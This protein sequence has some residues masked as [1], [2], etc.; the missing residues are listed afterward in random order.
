M[1]ENWQDHVAAAVFAATTTSWFSLVDK[2]V[3]V[4]YLDEFFHIPQAQ[5][6]CAG[7]YTWDPKITTPPGLYL[8]AKLLSPVLGCSLRSLRVQNVFALSFI[9]FKALQIRRLIQP[10]GHTQ[11]KAGLSIPDPSKDTPDEQVWT[12]NQTPFSTA[13][14]AFNIA[15]FPPLFFFGGL[16]YTDVMST[17]AVLISYDVFIKRAAKP[18]WSITDDLLTVVI[19][20]IAF[21]FR[22]TNIFWVAVFPAGLTVIRVLK[23]NGHT[24]ASVT[25]QGYLGLL[26]SSWSKGLIYDRSL[27]EGGLS[28][29][30]ATMLLLTIA[31]S[32][33]RSP[34]KLLRS[35]IPYIILLVLFAGFVAWNGSVVLG[36]KS[37]HTA[38][39][40]LPQMLYIWPYIAL[41]SAPIL[42]GPLF[43]FVAVLLPAQ[44]GAKLG[45]TRKSPYTVYPHP[46]QAI[47]FIAAG[48]LAVHF[49]TIIH[50][51]TLADNRHYV[52]YVFRILL[53]H[54]ALKY[55][56]VPVYYV[57]FWLSIQSL[58]HP[59]ADPEVPKQTCV[60]KPRSEALRSTKLPV[61]I[62]FVVIWL[63]TTTLSV[64]TAPLVE[65]R[66]FIIP[67]IVWR[68]H[69]PHAPTTFSL[70]SKTFSPD[71]RVIFE[72]VWLI[73]INQV[74]E[75][76]FLYRTFTWPSEPGKVQR[77]LW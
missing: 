4:P 9:F 7:D 19:G 45:A 41:F 67:W 73:A 20:V 39:I 62:S 58:A 1:Y 17:A 16:Y 30:D 50:P 71:L 14:I 33:L 11:R 26:Q 63:L 42:I 47:L 75:Y 46:L 68:L 65:P 8:V 76:L 72:T 2:D 27:K 44:L 48:L 53:R 36:D 24:A 25:G 64:V 18:Q 54:P 6:Y 35:V 37:A 56:A 40:H 51:Y 57:C 69:V 10:R 77:F 52:F 31:I 55:L 22:Q 66:Y 60:A 28:V 29:L 32:A 59:T 38:T 49:N 74:L 13:L 43:S 23:E 5:K 12:D 21:S 3:K 34:L 61:Q 70:G 15:S